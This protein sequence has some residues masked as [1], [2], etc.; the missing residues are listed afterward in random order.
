MNKYAITIGEIGE[1]Y[2]D[3]IYTDLEKV[4]AKVEY[5]TKYREEHG[6]EK[7]EYFIERLTPEREEQHNKEWKAW[8]SMID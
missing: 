7:V 5:L 8:V 3:P 1:F 6:M 4:K 2:P